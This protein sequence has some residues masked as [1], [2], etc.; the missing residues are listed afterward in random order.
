MGI[1]GLVRLALVAPR[2]LMESVNASNFQML[3]A[4]LYHLR[5]WVLA[6]GYSQEWIA[7]AEALT[8][9]ILGS[10]LLSGVQ[11]RK[12]SHPTT[13]CTKIPIHMTGVIRIP[14]WS[15]TPIH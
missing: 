10:L 13:I 4:I 5:R 1:K 3:L 15:S 11:L 12:W 8:S 9:F 7:W 6:N 2:R 14:A